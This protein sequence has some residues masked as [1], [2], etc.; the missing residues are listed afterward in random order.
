MR[1]SLP[2]ITRYR[3]NVTSSS[4]IFRFRSAKT[5][6]LACQLAFASIFERSKY[7]DVRVQNALSLPA[8]LSAVSP[9]IT[10]K[11]K[12]TRTSQRFSTIIRRR[13]FL[14]RRISCF[15]YRRYC[16]RSSSVSLSFCRVSIERERPDQVC[17]LIKLLDI[18]ALNF[19]PCDSLFQVTWCNRG[20]LHVEDERC[21]SSLLLHLQ[22]RSK[23]HPQ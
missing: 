4:L 6:L 20:S 23:G 22:L 13:Y 9:S 8:A 18:P 15:Y 7:I 21:F 19:E 10:Q 11:K 14:V 17:R 3:S 5:T 12:R 1:K 16:E 2:V